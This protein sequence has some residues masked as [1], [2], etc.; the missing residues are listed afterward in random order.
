MCHARH[1]PRSSGAA[2]L[3]RKSTCMP[4]LRFDADGPRGPSARTVRA[5]RPRGPSART[6]PADHPRVP[7]A[8]TIRA[9]RPRGPSARTVRADRPRGPSARIARADRPPGPSAGSV[10]AWVKPYLP[11]QNVLRLRNQTQHRVWTL[12]HFQFSQTDESCSTAKS[13]LHP[14]GAPQQP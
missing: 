13:S 12:H 14:G 2:S 3:T 8:R 10:R 6:A 1:R 5:D 7:P 9:Y 11:N 4:L